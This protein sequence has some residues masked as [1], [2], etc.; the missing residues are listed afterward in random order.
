M[1]VTARDRK[2]VAE[3]AEGRFY[4]REQLQLLF[5]TKTSG[6]QKAQERLRGLHKAKLLKRRRVGSHAGYIYYTGRWSGKHNH[7]INLNWVKVALT[8]QLKSWQKLSV[9]KREYVFA[10]IRA[11][12]LVAIDNTVQKNRQVFFVEIDNATNPFV[13]KYSS[14]YEELRYSLEQPWWM[15]NGFP[16]ILVVT[17][18]PEK[19][20]GICQSSKV[21]YCIATIEE[22]R[23]DVFRCL[24]TGSA[25]DSGAKLHED[26]AIGSATRT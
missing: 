24:S 8:S 1:R 5:F 16:R 4:L 10:D 25:G 3:V 20:L 14:V 7:W 26:Y 13:E 19:V 2:I 23:K 21:R 22:I 11:D 12:G 15:M 17:S 6:P 18:R 9:F